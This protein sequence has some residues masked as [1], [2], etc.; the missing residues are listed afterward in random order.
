MLHCVYS[1]YI[2]NLF[3]HAAQDLR[4]TEFIYEN[5]KRWVAMFR[6]VITSNPEHP[7][8]IV[9]YEELVQNTGAQLRRMLAFLGVRYDAEELDRRLMKNLATFQRQHSNSTRLPFTAWQLE[10]VKKHVRLTVQLL[11]KYPHAQTVV[12]KYYSNEWM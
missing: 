3:I 11:D 5:M 2:L 1:H 7:V 12:R 8:L 6:Y 4:W 9:S 10:A